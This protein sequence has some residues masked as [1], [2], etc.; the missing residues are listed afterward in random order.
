MFSLGSS[1]RYFLYSG[2][3][4]MRKGFDSLAGLVRSQMGSDPTDGSVYVFLN[5]SRTLIK[6]LHWEAGGFTLYYKRLEK[7]TFERPSLGSDHLLS[8]QQLVLVTEGIKLASVRK[9]A[10]YKTPLK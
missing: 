7:G 2:P 10:R 6:L 5:K 3:T 4:D 1:N 9:K 8:W